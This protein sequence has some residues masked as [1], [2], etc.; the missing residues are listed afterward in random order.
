MILTF[1]TKWHG[2]DLT[3]WAKKHKKVW[4]I[5]K[6]NTTLTIYG[7][8]MQC[9]FATVLSITS[10]IFLQTKVKILGLGCERKHDLIIHCKPNKAYKFVLY[11]SKQSINFKNADKSW[12]RGLFLHFHTK[13][14]ISVHQHMASHYI[15]RFK[16]KYF[17]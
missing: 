9:K 14:S 6:W 8:L 2:V 10:N 3:T 4:K 7:S 11:M 17:L 13:K 15:S 12:F 1:S 5:R 16:D